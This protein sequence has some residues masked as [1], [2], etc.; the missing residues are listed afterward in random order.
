VPGADPTVTG[1]NGITPL[2][3]A[4]RGYISTNDG[5][6]VKTIQV[7]LEAGANV[8]GKVS[9]GWGVGARSLLSIAL[10]AYYRGNR[11]LIVAKLLL[12]YGARINEEAWPLLPPEL[13]EQYVHQRVSAQNEVVELE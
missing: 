9:N 13:Q 11:N 2:G 6:M 8:E 7:L 10:G 5:D 3:E 4:F 12:E 1:K